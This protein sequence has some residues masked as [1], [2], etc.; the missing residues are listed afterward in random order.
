MYQRL[1]STFT[2]SGIGYTSTTGGIGSFDFAA[3]WIV[4]NRWQLAT[5]LSNIGA[6][7]NWEINTGDFM[8]PTIEDHPLPSLTL[9]S[10]YKGTFLGK[11]LLWSCDLKGYYFDG[12]WNALPHADLTINNG[13]EWCYWDIFSIRAG[14]GDFSVN[15]DIVNDMDQ[16]KEDFSLRAGAGFSLDLTRI[17]KGLVFNYGVSTDK[18][19]A[20]I[21][22]QLD[23]S[24]TF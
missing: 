3:T 24:Y 14:L 23:L 5:V 16:Y 7:M 11:P 18:S 6:S 8:N 22:Q 12:E 2:E 17:K 21:D 19:W 15:S 9:A 1:P 20:G 10:T 13:V 4:N